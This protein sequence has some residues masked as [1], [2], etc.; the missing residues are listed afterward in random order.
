MRLVLATLLCLFA[1][2]ARA[3]ETSLEEMLRRTSR[4]I[5]T[6]ELQSAESLAREAVTRHPQSRDARVTLAWLTLW[7]GRY[8]EAQWRFA[9]L[10]AA[11]PADA[12]ARLGL[13]QA[14]YWSGDVRR[15][16]QEF[17]HVVRLDP[18]NAAAQTALSE[19]REGARPGYAIELRSLDDDQPYR[20]P[21]LRTSV[22][23]FSDPLTK[24]SVSA[25]GARFSSDVLDG[26]SLAA[27]G[28]VE[29]TRN[30]LTM[31]AHAT[32][33]RF[34]D[35]SLRILPRL[36]LQRP[37]G[38]T[39]FALLAERRELLRAAPALRTHPTV[40]SLS[41]RWSRERRDALQFAVRAEALRY[42]DHNRGVAADAYLLVPIRG[43]TIGA[44]TA[45]RDTDQTRFDGA[46]YDPYYT[47]QRLAEAR[48]V[49]QTSWQW[50]RATV[51]IHGDGGVARDELYGVRRSFHPWSA[52]INAG[53]P[54][55]RRLTFHVRA[56]H[57]STI[58]YTANE[59]S[60]GVAGRF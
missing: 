43:F 12:G 47:P 49:A 24:W 59:I 7:N 29:T 13:A 19:I 8:A 51:S 4:L 9:E 17:A 22:Y 23:V 57:Q 16:E 38:S 20:A 39:T 60:T 6:R 27:G 26:N 44:S 37:A 5:E 41:A 10:V 53:V 11:S 3:Q 21:S 36:E 35:E 34:P 32:A 15:A 58:Y 28:G 46:R 45:W 50:Q 55:T 33:L 56:E 30:R 48:F 14:L 52:Y 18:R 31:R 1:T 2:L 40:T 54:F 25:S 42:F